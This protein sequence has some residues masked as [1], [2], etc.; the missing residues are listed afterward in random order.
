MIK[1]IR[2]F[3]QGTPEWF[4]ARAGKIGGTGISKVVTSTGKRSTQRKTYLY[5]LAGEII[6][7]EKAS[8]YSN[9]YMKNGLLNE[10]QTRMEFQ[11]EMMKQVEEVAGIINNKYP[12]VF[13][14]P[15]GLI[16]GEKAGL[17]LKSVIPAT[18]AKYLDKDVLPTEYKLQ[19]QMSLMVSEFERWYFCSHCPGMPIFTKVVHRD[20]ELIAAIKKEVRLFVK[21]LNELVKKIKGENI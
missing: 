11:L 17:E 21:E 13:V 4:A 5:T 9:Q 16:I 2:D 20:E 6:T 12:G 3:D 1:I 19:V 7:G 10:E 18:Q 15:D 14:S 8:S